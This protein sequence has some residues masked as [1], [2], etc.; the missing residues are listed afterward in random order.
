MGK[1]DV[2]AELLDFIEVASSPYQAVNKS[3]DIL[4]ASGFIEL[5]PT[6]LWNLSGGKS[7]F[8]RIFDSSLIAF[9]IGE[10]KEGSLRI[11]TAH[12]DFPC[13]KIK[14]AASIC[15]HGY[16]KINVEVYGGMI[17]SSWMDRPLSMAGKV[18]LKSNDSFHPI[19]KMID[20]KRALMAIPHLAIHMNRQM[21]EGIELNP[22]KDL[23]PLMTML[24]RNEINSSFFNDFLAAELS[25]NSEDILSYELTLYPTETGCV[26][27]MNNEFISSPRLDN[28]TSVKACLDGIL[29]GSREDGINVIALFDNEEVGSKTKQ[30]A[31]SF[32][33][34]Q[35][36][37]RVYSALGFS[38]E[39][40]LMKIAGGFILSLDVAH[41]VHP[42]VP[43]KNDITNF[44]ILNGGVTLKIACSQSYAGDA[45][46]VAIVTGLCQDAHIP[47]QIFVNRS[48]VKGGSTLGSILSANLSIRTMDIGV[49]LLAMHS[50]REVIGKEDQKAIE[51]L[52][53]VFFS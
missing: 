40:F 4:E 20:I 51:K 12:T 13:L 11:A 14:P 34:P 2:A 16:G 46:A 29:K 36:L 7:Y 47:Y 23:I 22:Q 3:A 44:P 17:R 6:E 43:E 19:T 10:K 41:A 27:G 50:A 45:E 8:V 24:D 21:N 53:T 15:M 5:N 35:I 25:C 30:G 52:M 42:N 28:M 37:D 39:E 9:H 31:A 1:S 33:L 49:P 18:V 48:D 26:M 38:H 32:V